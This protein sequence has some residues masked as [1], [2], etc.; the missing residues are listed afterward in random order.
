MMLERQDLFDYVNKITLSVVPAKLVF[1]LPVINKANTGGDR[2]PSP[3][4]PLSP[5]AYAVRE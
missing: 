5:F 4:S 1:E 2:E 3:V